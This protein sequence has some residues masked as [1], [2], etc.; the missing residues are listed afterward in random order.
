MITRNGF[1]RNFLGLFMLLALIFTSLSVTTSAFA[2]DKTSSL[3]ATTNAFAVSKIKRTIG[4]NDLSRKS[5]YVGS[6][7]ITA[8]PTN[9]P[10]LQITTSNDSV[11]Y[12]AKSIS[13]TPNDRTATITVV[14]NGRK[15]SE[16]EITQKGAI[17]LKV[18]KEKFEFVPNK[19]SQY[20]DVECNTDWGFRPNN[21]WIKLEKL[22]S[23]RLKITADA[24][25][26]TSTRKGSITIT[27]GGVSK[28]VEIIQEATELKLQTEIVTFN[29]E[30]SSIIL[31]VNSNVLW[32]TVQNQDWISA[33]KSS[34][35]KTLKI[36]IENKLIESKRKGDFI[37]ETVNAPIYLRRI[38]KVTDFGRPITTSRKVV[39]DYMTEMASI[40][41][42]CSN[43]FDYWKKKY[44][45]Q[46]LA[47]K[48]YTGIPYTR[49]AI[50]SNLEDFKSS[51]K[52]DPTNESISI[53]EYN[54]PETADYG[55]CGND[56]ST[57]V[58]HSWTRFNGINYNDL[59]GD[60][61][62]TMIDKS[63]KEENG[64][65]I[66]DMTETEL[67]NTIKTLP[68]DCIV[69]FD[70]NYE[71]LQ[72]GDA[73][74]K[75]QTK[76]GE[77]NGHARLV[78]KVEIFYNID[79][80]INEGK[81]LIYF[82]EQGITGGSVSFENNN[83][84]WRIAGSSTFTECRNDG[85]YALTIPGLILNHT[86]I[87]PKVLPQELINYVS[88]VYKYGLGRSGSESEVEGW[89]K[90]IYLG[91]SV[92][93]IVKGIFLSE[94]GKNRSALISDADFVK[95]LYWGILGRD[96]DESGYKSHLETLKNSK[97]DLINTIISSNEF[98]SYSE[99]IIQSSDNAQIFVRNL[100]LYGLLRNPSSSEVL[101]WANP[102]VNKKSTPGQVAQGIL[103]SPESSDKM[104]SI[105]NEN[106][107][108]NTYKGLLGS[109]SSYN[110]NKIVELNNSRQSLIDAFL[111]SEEFR[112]LQSRLR[113]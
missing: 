90:Q 110:A 1:T 107:V 20:L 83:T 49:N 108:K 98:A 96:Y 105:T 72:S 57:A 104:L 33:E 77:V 102:V 111:G 113:D 10:W 42:K 79:G 27:A 35:G 52:K 61:T 69:S 26:T 17:I 18:S 30:E 31:G 66:K 85:Y 63:I 4:F 6:G 103:F 86:P 48:I 16:I 7:K 81:S 43:T 13:T 44:S 36:S 71:K 91:K 84:S 78:N 70:K 21:Y 15:Y 100:Y 59:F 60:Y 92:K 80:T 112:N 64:K 5:V 109:T 67:I 3:S 82:T 22:S 2:A 11:Y 88:G 51:L 46:Y 75:N 73:I 94:E 89:A 106:F 14:K 38:I 93:D 95:N 55:Y 12:K 99:K 56:C 32:R 25:E 87:P 24:N 41:W 39:V 58:M 19:S 9:I 101:G 65:K 68:K 62:G 47:G 50:N 29:G 45:R 54:Q 8:V 76:D 28:D 53:Y 40:E 74:V 37:I 34:D 23:K 97:F